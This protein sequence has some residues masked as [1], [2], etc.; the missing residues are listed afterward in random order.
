MNSRKDFVYGCMV[1]CLVFLFG[2][3]HAAPSDIRDVPPG[4]W[5]YEAV[6]VLV[7][8]GYLT[9]SQDG[10]FRGNEPVDRYT[11]ASA[12]ARILSDIESGKAQ[13]SA[14]DVQ[15][16]R[17]LTNDYRAEL[18]QY[19]AKQQETARA[20]EAG[21]KRFNVLD[22]KINEA[23]M[24]LGDLASRA[25]ALQKEL[26]GNTAKDTILAEKIDALR[27][28]LDK[29]SID[30]LSSREDLA[31]QVNQLRSDAVTL[32]QL[33]NQQA[34]ST[35]ALRREM[36]EGRQEATALA[37]RVKLEQDQKRGI[38]ESR[39][40]GLEKSAKNTA[41][42][43][44]LMDT[45]LNDLDVGLAT[46]RRASQ[47]DLQRS[48]AVLE[49][50]LANLEGRISQTLVED[51]ARRAQADR[52]L[53]GSLEQQVSSLKQAIDTLKGEVGVQSNQLSEAEARLFILE[54]QSAELLRADIANRVEHEEISKRLSELGATQSTFMTDLDRMDG[55]LE[56]HSS[57]LADLGEKQ[58]SQQEQ[59]NE[60][61]GRINLRFEQ[62]LGTAEQ[63]QFSQITELREKLKA[64]E[65]E[66]VIALRELKAEQLELRKTT[67]EHGDKMD[68]L[69][70]DFQDRMARQQES[71][72]SDITRGDQAVSE[73]LASG[74][75][76]VQSQFEAK[77]DSAEQR[78]I[79]R[80]DTLSEQLKDE[81][82][83]RAAALGELKVEQ[84]RLWE[85]TDAHGVEMKN[86][87]VRF[88]DQLAAQEKR[89]R[90][91]IISGDQAVSQAL[92]SGLDDILLK[93]D[94]MGTL[95]NELRAV[96]EQG[97]R[98]LETD[99][100]RVDQNLGTRMEESIASLEQRVKADMMEQN[101]VLRSE[102]LG[103]MIVGDEALKKELVA[104]DE[105]VSVNEEELTRIQQVLN[106]HAEGLATQQAGMEQLNTDLRREYDAKIAELEQRNREQAVRF[107]QELAATSAGCQKQL[108][109][110]R[111]E[112]AQVR[113]ELD[114]AAARQLAFESRMGLSDEQF[115]ELDRRIREG[116][117][118]H[119]NTA[120][121]RERALDQDIAELKE[122]YDKDQKETKAEISKVNSWSWATAALA[123]LLG[124]IVPTP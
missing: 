51:T 23:I 74:L 118:D 8:K 42:K 1:L 71:L 2:V 83:E 89:L 57:K 34:T 102:M 60:A 70:V 14:Y 93:L 85:T 7:S 94:E 96:S 21:N 97:D 4:H 35:A 124:I 106:S 43:L 108:E 104:V 110:L 6:R 90:A 56:A 9:V 52:D 121:A 36:Q 59:L 62:K 82:E 68:T 45:R 53:R 91:E 101:T 88:D 73:A 55:V 67:E 27:R 28:D 113:R 64:E 112:L 122:K 80:V 87:G 31:R 61:L 19:Y 50:D 10:T 47:E 65:D 119:L 84:L 40:D 12:L 48:L 100:A 86:L 114:A 95:T 3:A 99:L 116:L 46:Y 92:A 49:Q 22:E 16:L 25:D 54:Q 15:L 76:D 30:L 69:E 17:K 81:G 18:V 98:Q 26:T 72:R 11:L 117:A 111:A 109:S 5:A 37:N 105:R 66:R 33:L 39:T 58:A 107:E 75:R 103:R 13:A 78:Q 44:H 79:R 115:A 38:L 41:E 120:L 20:V 123:A 29:V 63:Q 32:Q 24:A 77:L